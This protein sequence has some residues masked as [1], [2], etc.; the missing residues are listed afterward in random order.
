MNPAEMQLEMTLRE[1]V[2]RNLSGFR[3]RVHAPAGLRAAAVAV[4]LVGDNAGRACF[5]ITRRAAH[6]RRHAGQWALPG[7]RLDPGEDAAWAALR[8]LAEEISTN[9]YINVMGQYRPAWRVQERGIEPLNRPVTPAE[10]EHAKTIAR[11]AGLRLDQRRSWQL[12]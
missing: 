12:W 3:R 8:E 6:L 7:G 5:V 11:R 10:V 2:Q 9:T 1:R 4:T